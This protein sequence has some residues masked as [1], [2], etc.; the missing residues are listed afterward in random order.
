M[1]I[2]SA[3]ASAASTSSLLSSEEHPLKEQRRRLQE[4]QNKIIEIDRI[5]TQLQ[6]LLQPDKG[7][8]YA[9]RSSTTS[10]ASSWSIASTSSMGSESL[11]SDIKGREL[12]VPLSSIAY[13]PGT[14]SK[15]EIDEEDDDGDS[16]P[17]VYMRKN[18]GTGSKEAEGLILLD[19]VT[20]GKEKENYEEMTIPA[21][22]A[23][24]DAQKLGEQAYTATMRCSDLTSLYLV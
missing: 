24:L 5:K 17:I 3:P 6:Q 11:A 7:R 16:T 14:I 1:T 9:R 4:T 13:V 15:R 19:D 2:L 22:I 12:L 18:D 21:A 8:G 20:N 23:A 10:E